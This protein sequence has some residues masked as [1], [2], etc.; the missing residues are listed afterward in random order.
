MTHQSHSLKL[1]HAVHTRLWG[2]T[3]GLSLCLIFALLFSAACTH[4]EEDVEP[5]AVGVSRS[6]AE[7][8]VAEDL[9]SFLPGQWRWHADSTAPAFNM[10]IIFLG[11]DALSGDVALLMTQHDGDPEPLRVV[12]SAEQALVQF[13]DV[14]L[15]CVVEEL[16]DERLVLRC[17]GDG[18]VLVFER[19]P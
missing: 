7:W 11:H 6:A 9:E 16:G 2:R 10:E 8:R 5:S 13:E 12:V 1:P 4:S 3:H 14:G 15:E 17:L 19:I 18:R